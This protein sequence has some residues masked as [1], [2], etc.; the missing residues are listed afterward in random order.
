MGYKV[1]FVGWVTAMK[2][3]Q[4][5]GLLLGKGHKLKFFSINPHWTTLC[6]TV[7]VTAN[8]VL[9]YRL[10]MRWTLKNDVDV[11][12][13]WVRAF[14]VRMHL[15][16]L[17]ALCAPQS[18]AKSWQP[19]SFVNVSIA[20]RFRLLKI[21]CVQEKGAQ[22]CGSEWNQNFTF[23]QNVDWGFFLSSTPPIY[24]LFVSPLSKIS[25]EGVCPIKMSITNY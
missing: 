17:D 2:L 8:M 20:P 1:R 7:D 23:T 6:A 12:G 4:W 3:L 13:N 19:W 10:N 21:P 9:F 24:G 11:E 16:L 22:I 14:S 18:D 5:Q 25:S 15:G